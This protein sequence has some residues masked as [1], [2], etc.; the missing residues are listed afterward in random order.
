MK[1]INLK[2]QEWSTENY[3]ARTFKNGEPISFAK[4]PEEFKELTSSKKPCFTY[5][6]YDENNYLKYGC[7]YNWFALIDKRGIAPE[8]FRIPNNEDFSLLLDN[9]I[10]RDRLDDDKNENDEIRNKLNSLKTQFYTSLK[11]KESWNETNRYGQNILGTDTFGFSLL[12]VPGLYEN[13]GYRFSDI[14]DTFA[15]W[16]SSKDSKYRWKLVGQ[17]FVELSGHPFKA[18]KG[19]GPTDS[20]AFIR[21]IK[22]KSI[23]KIENNEVEI[24]NQIWMNTN[25]SVDR[26][27][28][29][30]LILEAKTKEEWDGAGSAGVPAWCYYEND[31]NNGREYGKLYNWFA[32]NDSRGIA[33]NGFKIPSK[34]DFVL[35]IS[36][37]N[38]K[39]Y[40]VQKL[41]S[42]G[43]W[44]NDLEGTDSSGFNAIP[45][46][47]RELS[48][49][50]QNKNVFF[51]TSTEEESRY[52]FGF[53]FAMPGSS[54]SSF[55]KASG[56][57][58]RCIKI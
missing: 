5:Y 43:Y 9:Y 2:G 51:W 31:E 8:G 46:G 26:F 35:L 30:D 55:N 10:G 11:S 1:T 54:F 33:P 17:H 50:D 15:L 44:L 34:E 57:S 32:I 7:C 42:K 19:F 14:G 13:R 4:S 20:A 12:A 25:L 21:L 24:G 40:S 39:R 49:D 28:N 6:N 22:D 41:K 53:W 56:F 52:A 38:G 18:S 16:S 3:N 58:V 27:N 37:L 48:F 47:R 36:Q 45:S 29:G 23:E